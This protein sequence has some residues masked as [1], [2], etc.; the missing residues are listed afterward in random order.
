MSAIQKAPS[1]KTSTRPNSLKTLIAF[2]HGGD[3]V[4]GKGGDCLN[5]MEK[6]FVKHV[7]AARFQRHEVHFQ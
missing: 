2:L 3:L 4:P 6:M 1:V 7:N 5:G